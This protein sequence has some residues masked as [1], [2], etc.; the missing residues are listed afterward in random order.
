MPDNYRPLVDRSLVS[1]LCLV[2][3]LS[4]VCIGL[5]NHDYTITHFTTDT[6]DRYQA[7]HV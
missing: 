3:D 4:L 7:V 2:S 1:D 5:D 6:M